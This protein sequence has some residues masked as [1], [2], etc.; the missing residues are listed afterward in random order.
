MFNQNNDQT[1]NKVISAISYA[2]FAIILI[3]IP[4]IF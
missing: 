1:E 4:F 2:L 3:A